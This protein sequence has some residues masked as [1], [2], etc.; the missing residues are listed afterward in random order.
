MYINDVYFEY[1]DHVIPYTCGKG[2]L[3]DAYSKPS[4]S[5]RGIWESWHQFAKSV[6]AE[7]F[8]VLYSNS[9]SFTIGFD[10]INPDTGE[11]MR[12]KIT[13]THNYCSSIGL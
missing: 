1:V 3:Y 6:N 12:A 11:I 8:R 5:K 2:S 4:K 13:P 9:F 10:F 7:D